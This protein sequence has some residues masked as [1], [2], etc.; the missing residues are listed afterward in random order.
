MFLLLAVLD[1]LAVVGIFRIFE[2]SENH[3]LQGNMAVSFA[4]AISASF[5]V[6]VSFIFNV[7][8]LHMNF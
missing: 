1:F 7:V 2:R 8:I 4:H 6:T 5:I 3:F